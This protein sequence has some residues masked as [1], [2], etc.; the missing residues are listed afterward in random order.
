MTAKTKHRCHPPATRHA[1]F[2]LALAFAFAFAALSA[3]SQTASRA[4]PH[5]F[6]IGANAFLL[7]GQPFQIRCGEMHAAR[8]PREYWEHRLAMLRAMGLNTVCAYLFW[9]MHEPRPGEFN[10]S[11]QADAAEFCRLAQKHG[12]WVILR[13][14]P[15][16]CAEWEMGGLPWWLLRDPK[17]QLRTSYPGYMDAA[18]RY[19]SEV[20]RVLAPLQVTRGGPILMVQVENEYGSYG[21]DAAY[22]GAMRQAVLDAGF[23]VPL[24]ACNPPSDLRNG[25]ISDLFQ[26]VNFSSDAKGGFAAL[27]KIQPSGPLMCGEFYPGWFDTWGAPHHLGNTEKYL[28]ELKY[29]LEAGASFSIYM[30]HGGSTFGLWSGCDRPFKPDTSSY[31]Y[32]APINEAGAPTEKFFLTRELMRAHLNPGETIPAEPPAPNPVQTFAPVAMTQVAPLFKNLPTGLGYNSART[33][34]SGF[35]P[36]A[37]AGYSPSV[38]NFES[39]ELDLPHGCA[40]YRIT[41]PAGPATTLTARSIADFGFVF[42][43]GQRIGVFD[44]R[45]VRHAVDIPARDKPATLDILVEAIGRINFGKEIHDRK[46]LGGPVRLVSKNGETRELTGWGITTLPL[47]DAPPALLHYEPAAAAPAANMPAFWRATVTLNADGDTYLDMRN[48]GKGVV[49]INGRCLGRY[50]NIGPTQTMYV[51]GAWLRRGENEIVILDLLDHPTG[52]PLQIAGLSKPILDQ[53]RP[54]LDFARMLR[55]KDARVYVGDNLVAK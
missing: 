43:D 13:P 54:G 31:D 38:L 48:W 32:D 49:W 19:L 28:A 34:S 50:W 41:L 15:Y 18:K 3:F 36:T 52:T 35:S 30:A 29:M 37:T 21:S 26:V 2:F 55:I 33:A 1:P 5:R 42:L 10:W 47:D 4:A 7:D 12:L 27:R 46:G 23:D 44:R 40:L 6:E 51:P 45:F 8:V 14:G 20:G 22:M 39:P 11:G 9:N 24:F 16:S 53:L 17:M 25:F